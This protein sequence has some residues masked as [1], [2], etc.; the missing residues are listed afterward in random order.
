MSVKSSVRRW[1]VRHR[2]LQLR[3]QR[4]ITLPR[5]PRRARQV[6][7]VWAVSLVRNEADVIGLTVRNLLAQGVDGVIVL[8]HLST[9]STREVLAGIAAEDP[10]VHLGTYQDPAHRQA[11]VMSYLADR[12][13]RAGADWVVLFDADEFWCAQGGTVAEVLGG[14]EGARVAAAALHDAHPD[15]PEGVDLTAAGS[16]LLVETEPNTEKVAIRPEGW[17]WVDMGNHSALDL[18]RSAPS[19]LRILHIPYRSLGQMR[20]KAVNGAAAVRADTEFGPRVADHWKR[21][22]DYDGE[23][24]RE[25]AEATAP[26]RPVAAIGVP[27]PGAT[28]EDVLGGGTTS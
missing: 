18:A 24:E 26:R 16:R 13:R 3:T 11:R 2:P 9:D 22:A 20:A 8:D 14:I 5:V 10:R 25:W 7:S 23:I 28:W 1:I 4:A 17:A 27:A 21:L 15:G 19:E 6:G 12:A